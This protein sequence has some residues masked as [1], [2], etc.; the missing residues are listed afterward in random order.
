M[1]KIIESLNW[2]DNAA[3]PVWILLSLLMLWI[4]YQVYGMEDRKHAIFVLGFVL[5]ALIW[6][7]P[8][9]TYLFNQLE[10][11]FAG[12]LLTLVVSW[13]YWIRLRTLS[14]KL[15]RLMVPQLIWL[16]VASVYV[17]SLLVFKYQNA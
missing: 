7:Y 3:I 9:Y 15:S 11:G 17:G 4:Q 8:A 5:L 1:E 14:L 12:N 13:I 16:I 6:L 2:I 10:V